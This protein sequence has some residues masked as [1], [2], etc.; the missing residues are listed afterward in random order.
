MLLL[1]DYFCEKY[2]SERSGI[3]IEGFTPES[4]AVLARHSWPGNVRELENAV[5]RA[6]YLTHT[7]FVEPDSLSLNLPRRHPVVYDYPADRPIASRPPAP[8]DK[9]DFSIRKNE[10]RQLENALQACNGNVKKA[11]ALLEIS[12]RTMYRKMEKYAIQYDSFRSE[13]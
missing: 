9:D 7:P 10:R 13:D 4:R 6:V 11:A 2:G 8:P 3:R 1:A 5:E 12:R